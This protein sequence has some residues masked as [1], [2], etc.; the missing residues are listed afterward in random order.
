MVRDAKE[1]IAAGDIFQVV[2]SLRFARRTTAHPFSIYRALRMLN[3]AP[4]MIYFDFGQLLEAPAAGAHANRLRLIGASPELHARYENGVASVRPIAGTRRRGKTDEEDKA[5][6]AELMADPKERAEH[7]MLVDLGRNDVGRVAKFGSVRVPELM[8]TENYSHVMHIVSE[9]E[10]Q[11]RDGLDMFDVLRA[12][13]PAGTLSGAPKVRAMEII[14][15]L[16][17]ERR[18]VYGGCVGYFS[19]NQQMDTCIGIRTIVMQGDTCYIQAGAGVVADSDPTSEYIECTNKARAQLLA[20][21][22]A[23]E[24]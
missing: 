19:F 1:H 5:L 23:E 8:V 18:G 3:P 15:K 13:F 14:E 24:I 20:I 6:A 22:Q 2:P 16:E 17:G 7:V 9:V 10:G 21:D 4:W 12:T 11:L